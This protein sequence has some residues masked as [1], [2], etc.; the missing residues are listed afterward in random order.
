MFLHLTMTFMYDEAGVPDH[1]Y[2]VLRCGRF[3]FYYVFYSFLRNI[4]FCA[5][6]LHTSVD[7]ESENYAYDFNMHRYRKRRDRHTMHSQ[8]FQKT[9]KSLAKRDKIVSTK[10]EKC[11]FIEILSYIIY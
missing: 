6:N 9:Q 4:R 7:W 10:N 1:R 5:I 11:V 8:V 2:A 3:V